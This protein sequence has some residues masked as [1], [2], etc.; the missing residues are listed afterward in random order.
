MCLSAVNIIK[1]LFFTLS[2]AALASCG[3][4]SS[5]VGSNSSTTT[6][7]SSSTQSQYGDGSGGFTG[8]GTTSLSWVSPTTY[9]DGTT[10]D[11]LAG[12]NIYMN[13]GSGYVLIGTIDNPT[14]TSYLVENLASAVYRFAVTAFDS[15]GLE[16]SLSNEVT[17]TI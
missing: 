1:S 13:I 17:V 15:N 11:D 6:A 8:T 12:H 5:S 4:G 3:G 9:E 16:S 14:V 2:I 10:L 7:S